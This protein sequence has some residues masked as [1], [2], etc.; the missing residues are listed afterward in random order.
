MPGTRA[1]ETLANQDG[2]NAMST[3]EQERTLKA[4]ASASV[5]APGVTLELT[6]EGAR[7]A[8]VAARATGIRAR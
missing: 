3:L 1:L 2:W 5:R 6:R 4:R 8:A 7:L